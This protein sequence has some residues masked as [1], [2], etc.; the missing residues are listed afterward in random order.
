MAYN[1][2]E[3]IAPQPGKQTL[4]FKL[5]GKVDFM[6]MGGARFGGKSELLTMI[7][8]MFAADPYFRGIYFRRQYDE[9]M[10]ANG[11]WQKAENMYPHFFG[12][13]QISNKTWAFPKGAKQEFRHMYY[14]QDKE[15]HRGKGYSFIGFDEIDQFSKEQVQFLMTCLRSEADM[16]SFMVGT[17]NPNPDSWCLP[18]IEYYIDD[19]GLPIPEKCGEIR[20]FVVKE[21]E[22][23]FGDSEDYFK[24][25]HP[26][27]VYVSMP[28]SDEQIYVRPKTF[29]YMFFNIFD[30][31]LGLKANPAYLSELQN[32]PDH[33]RDTQ[34]WGNWYSR[35]RS[36]S[37]WQ[38]HW[39]RGEEG[40]RAKTYLDIPDNIRWYRGVDKGYSEPSDANK[41]PDYTA[42]SPKIGKDSEGK[43]WL[44]GEYHP[45]CVDNNE[46][47]LK[48][49][50]RVL[51][52]FRFLAGKRD[53]LLTTQALYD[54]EDT[55]YVLTKDTGGAATDH[56]FTK[57]RL[58]E[59]GVVVEEDKSPKNTPGKKLKDFQP[60]CNACAIG[61]VN[62]VEESFDK[63][64]LEAIYKE[65]ENFSPEKR[66]TS[67]VKDD[68]VD[69]MSMAFAASS[70]KRVK[71][72]VVRNQQQC[73][74]L[75][76]NIRNN[77]R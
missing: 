31:E 22:F 17:L 14:E 26:E 12:K 42:I 52:R 45:D 13:P 41:Y 55:T 28:H 35:P 5:F 61:L 73:P 64:T 19:K 77:F 71:N 46:L 51:G 7:P 58:I 33:E 24:E 49:S 75:A 60:F 59:E 32:L 47:K 11:L 39:V 54:G 10:G 15:S 23:I 43:Y 68:W 40:E 9:I 63:R 38:R 57:G 16:D 25:N 34:L 18:L 70:T 2:Q 50:Y 29:T 30:N 48:E 62:I 66:S 44:V 72:L 6:L 8:L 20:H 1:C 27:T 37:L 65:W 21:G 4:A 36:Q 3:D 56:E 67:A 69:S 53:T 76:A 74:T